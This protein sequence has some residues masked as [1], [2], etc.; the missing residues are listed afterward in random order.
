VFDRSAEL[1]RE[2]KIIIPTR[3]RL[4]FYQWQR[5]ELLVPSGKQNAGGLAK[6]NCGKNVSIL[7]GVLVGNRA[8]FGY[9]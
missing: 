6:I 7:K 9:S 1:V 3:L 8:S 4:Y 5:P 2:N